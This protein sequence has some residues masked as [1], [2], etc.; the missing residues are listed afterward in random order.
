MNVTCLIDDNRVS[1]FR[2]GKMIGYCSEHTKGEGMRM[3]FFEAVTLTEN[4]IEI[5]L[6]NWG[7]FNN[8]TNK[9]E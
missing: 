5:I 8:L 2:Y 6:D 3:V 1:I 9:I 7:M 4:D